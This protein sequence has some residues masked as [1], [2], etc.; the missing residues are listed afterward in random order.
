VARSA[1]GAKARG[2]QGELEGSVASC[3]GDVGILH[4]KVGVPGFSHFQM[5][6]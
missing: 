1:G 4:Y 5:L 3:P 6:V 2:K